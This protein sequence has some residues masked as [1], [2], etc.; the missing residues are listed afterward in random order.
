MYVF[1]CTF[2]QCVYRSQISEEKKARTCWETSKIS[3][4]QWRLSPKIPRRGWDEW[5]TW[6]SCANTCRKSSKNSPLRAPRASSS[7]NDMSPMMRQS[8]PDDQLIVAW[9]GD[10]RHR[11]LTHTNWFAIAQRLAALAMLGISTVSSCVFD[12]Y[13]FYENIGNQI[14][15]AFI[16]QIIFIGN[17]FFYQLVNE[18]SEWGIDFMKVVWIFDV[19]EMTQCRWR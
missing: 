14:R 1:P 2:T 18:K 12:K 16:T 13:A 19:L 9:A 5:R 15:I 17:L 11:R 4:S 3:K 8:W 6:C 10:T 7:S